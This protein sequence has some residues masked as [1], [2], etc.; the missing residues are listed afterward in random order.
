MGIR[1]SP[2]LQAMTVDHDSG[3][4]LWRQI[5]DILRGQIERKE[6]TGRVPS[7]KTLGQEHGVSHV[8]AEHALDAL[9]QEGLIYTVTGKGSYV[10]RP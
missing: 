3:V 9:R 7:I 5:A 8:T 6:L 10:S 1:G 2:T 4:P